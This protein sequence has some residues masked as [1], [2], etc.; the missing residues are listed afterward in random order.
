MFK[1]AK[2]VVV[3]WRIYSWVKPVRERPAIERQ[4]GWARSRAWIRDFSSTESTMALSGGF[5]IKTN[6]IELLDEVLDRTKLDR[7]CD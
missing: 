2:S 7:R 5:K 6:D 1:A 3:P 4:P